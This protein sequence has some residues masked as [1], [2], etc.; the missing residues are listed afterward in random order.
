MPDSL[1]T[2]QALD[3]LSLQAWASMAEP[4]ACLTYHVGNLAQDKRGDGG[5][6]AVAR[7]AMNLAGYRRPRAADGSARDWVQS[8]PPLV[9]LFQQRM[10]PSC[11]AYRAVRT[12]I[13]NGGVGHGEGK[14]DMARDRGP[15][16]THTQAMLDAGLPVFGGP[17]VH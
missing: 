6:Q 2:F 12:A 17:T 16:R 8:G 9:L 13:P 7:L 11:W 1:P 10:G 14:S 4:G 15:V 5:L 3:A